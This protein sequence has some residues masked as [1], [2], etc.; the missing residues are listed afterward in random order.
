MQVLLQDLRYGARMLLKRPGFTVVAVLTLALGIGANTA[1]FSVV[2]GA[3]LSPL[4]FKEPDRL[5]MLWTQNMERGVERSDVSLDDYLDWQKGSNGFEQL[6]AYGPWGFNITGEAEP[7]K[8]TSVVVTPNFFETLGVAPARGRDFLPEEAL[9]SGGNVVI[10]SY[11]LW[12]RRYGG[13]PNLI[14]QT[15]TLDGSGYRVVGVMPAGFHFP[16]KDVEMWAPLSLT[17]DDS[18]RRS[19]WLKVI[20]RLKPATTLAQAGSE[21]DVVAGQLALVYPD[22]D[23]GWGARITSLNEEVV[24]DS[25]F[26]LLMLLAAVGFV[27][28]I[29]CV[30]VANLLLARM[31]ARQKEMAIRAALGARRARLI[32]QL[33]TESL[34]LSATGGAAGLLL[35]L[36]GLEL[37]MAFFPAQPFIG[38]DD[39]SLL[40]LNQVSLDAR[41]LGFTF[42][43][44]TLTGTVFGL[45]PVYQALRPDLHHSLKE[46]G[47]TS[48]ASSRSPLRGALVVA[49]V[50]LTLVLL[51][52]A[53]LLI[54]SFVSLI[55]VDPG[56]R[57]ENLL[58]FR[59]SPASKY[60]RSQDRMAYY[61][62]VTESIRSL[63]GVESVGATTSLPFSGTDLSAPFSIEGRLQPTTG[64]V[65]AAGFHSITQDYL[66]TM[67]IGLARG[68]SFTEQDAADKPPVALINETMARR[69][70]SG[71]DPIGKLM[72]IRFGGNQP[73]EIVGI[74]GDTRQMG[75]EAEIKPE[76]YV[77][78][79]QRPWFFITFAV[80]T[81]ADPLSFAGAIKNRVWSIDRDIPIYSLVTMD[82]RISDSIAR[83]RFN[84][85][86]LG[87]FAALALVLSVVGIYGVTAYSVGQR[88]HEIG[89]RMA[90]GAG[91]GDVLRMV[92]GQGMRLAAAGVALGLAGSYALTRFMSSMLFGVKAT[93]T[94]T[95]AIVSLLLI[96]AAMLACYIPARRAARVDPMVALRYE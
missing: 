57:S 14:D 73:L 15:L 52:G 86:L 44:S 87:L 74:V 7:E 82:D 28:L 42:L 58:T 77:P 71:E 11:G 65:P 75:L 13:N 29:A 45:A 50:A 49:E 3:L 60:R 17:P 32:R 33:L 48:G 34:L 55:E 20:G 93:D 91:T 4:P 56:F 35:A 67:G 41:V 80:R 8:I 76:V 47:R 38:T 5:V 79:A 88:T 72:R 30:N 94:L 92:F 2:N 27:L 43:L 96:A 37:I 12:Q 36:W 59:L 23:A 81:S 66:S 83:R 68:R 10:I 61:E 25:R 18:S 26:A 54:R 62:R 16:N 21:L 22:I 9:Q 19:R 85:L 63:P 46:G 1:I 78:A 53:G 24:K 84:M 70:F 64:E 90:L 89:V 40:Q 95:F 39:L 31:D 69:Y 6:A 51:A